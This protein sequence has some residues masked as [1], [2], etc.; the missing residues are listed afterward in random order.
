MA[1]NPDSR[2]ETRHSLPFYGAV[3]LD[4]KRT[5]MEVVKKSTV[6]GIKRQNLT[7]LKLFQKYETSCILF[8]IT[9][10]D[11]V[12]PSKQYTYIRQI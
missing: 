1:S 6:T 10:S 12:P 9:V 7:A 11:V 5:R 8:I 4:G 3:K 2:Q